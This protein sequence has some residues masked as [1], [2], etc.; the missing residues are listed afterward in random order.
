MIM[1]NLIDAYWNLTLA[2]MHQLQCH[3][4]SNISLGLIVGTSVIVAQ[5][6]GGE[7]RGGKRD[8]S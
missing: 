5:T 8:Y 2:L 7:T 4:L 1:V 3:L 6:V